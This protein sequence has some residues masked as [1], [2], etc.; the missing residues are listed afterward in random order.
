[1][2]RNL[3]RSVVLGAAALVMGGCQDTLVVQ[4]PNSGET[5]RVLSTPLDAENLLGPG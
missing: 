3:F 5:D 1:M 2:N 4:N